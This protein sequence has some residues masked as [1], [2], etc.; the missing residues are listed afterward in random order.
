MVIPPFIPLKPTLSCQLPVDPLNHIVR[1]PIPFLSFRAR[2]YNM[3]YGLKDGKFHTDHLFANPIL[4]L[5]PAS[6]ECG[7]GLWKKNLSLTMIFSS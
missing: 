6:Q 5:V 7:K 3:A 1:Y 4:Y 2:T